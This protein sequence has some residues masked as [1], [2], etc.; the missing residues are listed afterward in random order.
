[1]GFTDELNHAGQAKAMVPMQV[2][3][4]DCRDGGGINVGPEY[5]SAGAFTT[6]HQVCTA[7][8]TQRNAGDISAQAWVAR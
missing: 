4:V 6:V 7:A 3:D 5:L 1:M 8:M 2:T